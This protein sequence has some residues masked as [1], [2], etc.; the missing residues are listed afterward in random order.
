MNHAKQC[1]VHLVGSMP[2]GDAGEVMQGTVDIL[3]SRT[4]RLTNGEVGITQGW[5]V[6]HHR[7]FA[8]HSDFE[9]YVHVERN[10]P[11]TPNHKRRRFRLKHGVGTPT[12]ELFGPSGYVEDATEAYAL[13]TQ[14]KQNG[15][16]DRATRLLV[17]IPTPY[18]ILNFAI[19][20]HHFTALAPVYEQYLLSEVRKIAQVIPAGELAFQWDAAH[21]F[22][23][24]ATSSL[25]FNAMSREEMVDMLVRLGKGTPAGAELG[26]HC[27]YGNF[28]LKHFVEPPDTS[29]MVDVMN[30]VVA[31]VGREVAFI[32]MPVPID[33]DDIAYFAPLKKLVRPEETELYLGLT[34]DKDGVPGALRRAAVAAKVVDDFG[35]STECGLGMRSP[36]NIRQILQILADAAD[37]LSRERGMVVK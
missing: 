35:I 11:R 8:R 30:S 9:E 27:C 19:D 10:D 18:D 22:E 33:R 16:V 31:G 2:L 12:A 15:R 20:Q 25:A 14:L 1:L 32:H 17:A 29:D 23:Y 4:K 28:N 26:Y 13:L 7:I 6:G 3:G 37:T 24:L 34:H 5:I 36:D 21:E